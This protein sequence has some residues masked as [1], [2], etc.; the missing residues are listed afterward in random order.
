MGRRPRRGENAGVVWWMVLAEWVGYRSRDEEDAGVLAFPAFFLSGSIRTRI[1]TI[2]IRTIRIRTIDCCLPCARV[3]RAETGLTYLTE[4]QT[5]RI[6]RIPPIR[7]LR[8]LRRRSWHRARCRR[9]CQRSQP[10]TA[11]ARGARRWRPVIVSSGTIMGRTKKTLLSASF[12]VPNQ[13][14]PN[15][16]TSSLPGSSSPCWGSA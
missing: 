9:L 8:S 10:G 7:S 12:P 14:Q 3:K 15:G 6:S 4:R 13:I 11:I 5:N 16:P 1:R 2:R